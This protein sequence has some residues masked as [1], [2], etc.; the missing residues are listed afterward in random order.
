GIDPSK[1][2]KNSLPTTKRYHEGRW[3]PS[4]LSSSR[5]YQFSAKSP[6]PL[7]SSLYKWFTRTVLKEGKAPAGTSSPHCC[8][9]QFG[10]SETNETEMKFARESQFQNDIG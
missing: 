9:S 5:P 4:R 6:K 7:I 2:R 8:L 10:A 1:D 3:P